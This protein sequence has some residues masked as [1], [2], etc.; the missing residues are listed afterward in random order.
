MRVHDRVLSEVR[1]LW[2]VLVVALA[3]VAAST[4]GSSLLD[5]ARPADAEGQAASETTA[6]PTAAGTQILAIVG[7]GVQAT[8]PLAAELPTVSYAPHASASIGLSAA[9]VAKYG[10]ACQAGRNALGAIL[11]LPQ[12]TFASYP[13][14]A[15]IQYF[16]TTIGSYDY[17]YQLPQNACANNPAAQPVINREISIIHDALASLAPLGQ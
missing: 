17:I 2:P 12:G 6:A 4:L 5:H 9:D 3:V 16:I 1:E 7:W 13:H 8:L 15:T 14:T 11:R 10:P